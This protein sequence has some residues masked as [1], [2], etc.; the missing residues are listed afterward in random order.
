MLIDFRILKSGHEILEIFEILWKSK[1][2]LYLAVF[3]Y[4]A[5]NPVQ[6]GL[7]FGQFSAYLDFRIFQTFKNRGSKSGQMTA[8]SHFISD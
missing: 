6:Q 8:F 5:K 4:L 7:N 3:G 1:N 2:S